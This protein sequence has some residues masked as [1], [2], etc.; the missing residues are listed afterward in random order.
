MK[1]RETKMK[2]GRDLLII[3]PN[4]YYF[5]RIDLQLLRG[6]SYVQNGAM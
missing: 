1:D 4:E 3:V 5:A 6:P 2:S